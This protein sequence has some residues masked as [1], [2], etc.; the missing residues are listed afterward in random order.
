MIQFEM[1]KLQLL[2]LRTYSSL[3]FVRTYIF[4]IS[5]WYAVPV[6]PNRVS[7]GYFWNQVMRKYQCI[8][9]HSTKHVSFSGLHCNFAAII[10]IICVR[11]AKHGERFSV[12]TLGWI[13]QSRQDSSLMIITGFITHA[14]YRVITYGKIRFADN[15]LKK[16]WEKNI[17]FV[18]SIC[19]H[20]NILHLSFH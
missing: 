19:S 14:Y 15:K 20:A 2:I 11:R 18:F 10:R 16:N 4:R 7:R 6:C 8:L 12:S 3:F 17:F 9:D 13:I 5:V 1:H